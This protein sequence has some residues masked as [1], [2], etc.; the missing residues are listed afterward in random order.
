Q[1]KVYLRAGRFEFTPMLSASVN[2]PYFWKFAASL[3]GGFY[4]ADTLAIA[5]R[6]GLITMASTDDRKLASQTFSARILRS[7]PRW[8]AMGDMEWSALYGKIAIFNSIFHFDA[9]V[10]GGVG[11]VYTLTSALPGHIPNPAADIGGGIRFQIYDYL[12]AGVAVINTSY[13]DQPLGTSKSTTQNIV[14]LYAGVS[15]FF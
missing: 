6:F 13:V 15:V 14:N 8:S 9:Y 5:A 12:A 2:D 7:E 1:R 10:V 3:R 11:V 4:L